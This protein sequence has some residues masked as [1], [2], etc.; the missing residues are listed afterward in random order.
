MAPS[1]RS[2]LAVLTAVAAFLGGT[3][4]FDVYQDAVPEGKPL[5]STLV[6]N[7]L[8]LVLVA[9]LVYFS[10]RLWTGD[11]DAAYVRSTTKWTVAGA[12]T[13]GVLASWVL[14]FQL[15]QN[16]IK[17]DIVAFQVTVVG[18]VAGALVGRNTAQIEQTRDRLRYERERYRAL[19]ENDPAGVVDLALTA[20][21]LRIASANGAFEAMYDR[22]AG[23]IEGE[24]LFDVVEGL[25]AE[26]ESATRDAVAAGE[27]YET[28]A[29]LRTGMGTRDLRLE[30]VP[31]EAP[32]DATRR[33]YAVFQDLT[34]VRAAERELEETV[35]ELERSNEHLQ[36]FAYVASHDLQEPVRMVSSYVDLLD[37]EYGDELDDEAGEYMEFAVD[38]AERIQDMIDALLRYSRVNTRGGE[39]VETDLNEVMDGVERDLELLADEH[40][41]TVESG[42]LPAAVGD[43]DQLGQLLQNLVK[44]GIEHGAENG[45]PTVRV[46]GER[47]DEE[48]VVSVT[49]DGPG[50]PADQQ[51]RVFRM[52]EQG[53]RES[54]GTGIGLAVCRRIVD[55]HGG[56]LEVESAEGEGTTFRFSVPAPDGSREETPQQSRAAGVEGP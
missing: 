54:D 37:A 18:T 43:G 19:F 26:T 36:Q 32:D 55:R 4:L 3:L 39:F 34:D 51:E 12:V 44:N 8:P 45:S 24:T 31:Y 7:A 23:R 28:E 5:W 47:R 13:M 10:Y 33:G 1:K 22:P 53:R 29:R 56:S 30:V 38:G 25:D 40:D 52:F 35:D 17:P 50:I 21:D 49:D 14:G 15:L 16:E 11:H 20:G 48:V 6:E 9:G 27:P 2:A 41:A 46:T 42:D